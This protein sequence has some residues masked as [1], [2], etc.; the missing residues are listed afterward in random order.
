MYTEISFPVTSILENTEAI[1]NACEDL[2]LTSSSSQNSSLPIILVTELAAL[3]HLQQYDHARHLWR[4]YSSEQNNENLLQ[5]SSLWKAVAPLLRA[6]S[7]DFTA[8]SKTVSNN[9]FGNIA[10]VYGSLQDCIEMKPV[11]EP[12]AS[13]AKQLQM[14]IR[15]LFCRG[16]ER[17]HES[18][19]GEKCRVLLGL[20]NT[21]ELE[22]FV[23]KRNWTKESETALWIPYYKTMTDVGKN[24]SDRIDYL[25]NV[26]G[27]METQRF[28]A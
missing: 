25:T 24:G 18:I 16:I 1:A 23:T 2:E 6:R 12:L 8:S 4:R 17:I 11:L 20:K 26:V 7:Q 28:N 22:A 13:Y 19:D 14:S 3:I 9:K 21:R 15:E 5:F 27:F 10:E